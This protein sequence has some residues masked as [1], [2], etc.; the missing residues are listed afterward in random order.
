[1]SLTILRSVSGK[2][3]TKR[4]YRDANGVII[5][6]NY[7]LEKWWQTEVARITDFA[8]MAA[9][10]DCLLDDPLA[11]PVRGAPKAGVDITQLIVRRSNGSDATIEDVPQHFL[12]LDLDCIEEPHLDVVSRPEEARQYALDLIASAAPELRGAACWMSWSSSAGVY[13]RTRVKLH[14]WYWAAEPYT[15]ARLKVWGEQVN[16]RA[17]FML[18]DLKLFQPVQA[19][20]VA[21]PLFEDVDDPFPG[22]ARAVV[23]E[24]YMPTLVIEDPPPPP[25]RHR[26]KSVGGRGGSSSASIEAAIASM[27]EDADGFHGPWLRAMSI[28]YAQNGPDADPRPLILRLV[29]AIKNH[30]TR[31]ATYLTNELRGMIRRARVLAA[32]ERTARDAVDNLRAALS[33]RSNTKEN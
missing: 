15:C 17:G 12:H 21:R 1:V 11:L 10:L 25:P 4:F 30:G 28:F 24:G 19:N 9:Q 29:R 33:R 23:V 20:Y 3:A 14:C 26:V 27:G 22:A 8:A 7:G 32:K 18:V 16:A 31:D 6:V 5:Q 2:L 13:D